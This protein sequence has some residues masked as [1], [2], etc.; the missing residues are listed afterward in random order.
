MTE[1][2]AVTCID[3]KSYRKNTLVGFANVRIAELKLEIKDVAVHEKNRK[4]WAQLPAKPQIRDGALIRGDD[5]KVQYVPMMSFASRAV[6]D[7]FSAACI[8]AVI[9]LCPEAFDEEHVS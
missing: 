3:F 4:R 7:A 5:G 8:K 1:K 9:D 2:F 6:S